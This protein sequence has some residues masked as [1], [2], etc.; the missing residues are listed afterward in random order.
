MP[1]LERQMA[2]LLK[3]INRQ[4]D[5]TTKKALKE[6]APKMSKMIKERTRKGFGLSD[7]SDKPRIQRLARLEKATIRQRRSKAL[8]SFTSPSKSNLTETGQMVASL[9][10][11]TVKNGLRIFLRDSRN[12]GKSN[13]ELASRHED[14]RVRGGKKRRF[15]GLSVREQSKI[16]KALTQS[17][18]KY[19]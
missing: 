6:T 11:R 8:S 18:S 15:V 9:A 12:D 2:N 16:V 1:S 14:G 10:V 17:L 5:K 19:F 4:A 13:N 7:G 3:E